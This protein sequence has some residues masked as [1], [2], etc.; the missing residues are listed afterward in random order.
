MNDL[1]DLLERALD[2]GHGPD[3]AGPADPAADL[4]RGRALLRGRRRVAVAGLSVGALGV[5]AVS[6]AGVAATGPAGP[7]AAAHPGTAARQ[8]RHVIIVPGASRPASRLHSIA[9]VAYQGEQPPGYR[10]AFMPRG[11][12]VQGGDPYVLTIAPK[13]DPDSQYQSFTGKL[14]VALLSRDASPPK[15]FNLPVAGRPGQYRVQDDTQILTFKGIDGRWVIIQSPKA[16]GWDHGRLA[17]FAAGV[18]VLGNASPSR[19]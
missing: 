13:G 12:V 11:W 5:A 18:Q 6:W 9:L 7:A 8:H 16:L 19:G 15:H 14:I 1:K 4:A 3:G 2:D 10:V 17:K